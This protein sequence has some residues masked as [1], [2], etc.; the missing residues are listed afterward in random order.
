MITG[1]IDETQHIKKKNKVALEIDKSQVEDESAQMVE[2][3]A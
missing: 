2:T 1:E 3:P